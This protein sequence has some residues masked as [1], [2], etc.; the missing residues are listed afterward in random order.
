MLHW[1]WIW[2]FHLPAVIWG[3]LVQYFVLICPLTTWENYFRKLGGE[4]GYENGFIEYFVTSI[5]YPEI[6]PQIH[7]T[8]GILL[9]LINLSIYFYIFYKKNHLIKPL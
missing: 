3:F 4:L 7:T 2:K 9:I 6:N 5:I 1:R 8:F